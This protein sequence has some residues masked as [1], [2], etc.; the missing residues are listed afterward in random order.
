MSKKHEIDRKQF[1]NFALMAAG[2]AMLGCTASD[3]PVGAGGSGG[4]AGSGGSASG[5]GGAGGSGGSGSG[6][7]GSGG[8]S[9]GSAG[10]GG[11]GGSAGTGGSGGSAGTGGSDGGQG[12]SG[13]GGADAAVDAPPVAPNCGTRLKI[14]ITGNH[15]HV[16]N[17]TMADVTAAVTKVYNVKGGS[18]HPHRIQV[19]AQDF[20]D[21][22]AGKGIRKL[23]CDDG[24]EHEYLVNCVSAEDVPNSN[25]PAICLTN[26]TCGNS[27]TGNFCP[28]S[29]AP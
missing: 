18:A 20:R 19:T 10:T 16:L 22:A 17:M 12:G 8:G 11:S 21:L 26:R 6:T 4:R 5:S 7:G 14:V 3:P 1:L 15:D 25:A 23:S 29:P 13:G 24:H 2:G 28:P 27:D 9:G